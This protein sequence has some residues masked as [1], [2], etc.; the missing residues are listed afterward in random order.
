M[1]RGDKVQKANP[2]TLTY[3]IIHV[4]M[5]VKNEFTCNIQGKHKYF[6]TS[7]M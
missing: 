5:I 7:I 1:C 3:V 2:E 6:Y 4:N